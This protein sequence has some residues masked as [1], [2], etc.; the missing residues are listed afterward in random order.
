M[1]LPAESVGDIEHVVHCR[2]CRGRPRAG[3]FLA[4]GLGRQ[5]GGDDGHGQQRRQDAG[6]DRGGVGVGAALLDDDRQTST[7]AGDARGETDDFLYYFFNF[8]TFYKTFSQLA[9]FSM[10][11]KPI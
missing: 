7:D 2:G 9:L 1:K 4:G 10:Y 3:L 6:S 8:P 11:E 5:A